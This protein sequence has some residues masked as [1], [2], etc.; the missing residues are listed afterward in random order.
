MLLRR[1]SNNNFK[2]KNPDENTIFK[3]EKKSSNLGY[4]SYTNIEHFRNIKLAKAI[5]NELGVDFK[6]FFQPIITFKSKLTEK[7]FLRAKE[8]IEMM[9]NSDWYNLRGKCYLTYQQ[10]YA[11]SYLDKFSNNKYCTDLSRL[12]EK[13]NSEV[14]F[15]ICH[16]TDLGNELIAQAILNELL[17]NGF[18]N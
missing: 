16:Y 14:F 5:S 2:I 1:I 9:F 12:F 18:L 17:S 8:R 3:L 15:D 11:N 7:E 6:H 4:N 13:E 10:D